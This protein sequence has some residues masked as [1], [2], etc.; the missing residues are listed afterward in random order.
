M[1]CVTLE[2]EKRLG[3]L[4]EIVAHRTV[5]SMAIRAVFHDIAVL[6]HERPLLFHVAPC[7]GFLLGQAKEH[8]LLATA[9]RIMTVGTCHLFLNDRVVGEKSV[10]YLYLRV[11]AIAELRHFV[12]AHFLLRPLVEL[13]AVE[14]ANVIERMGTGVPVS[15]DRCRGG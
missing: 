4:Q 11:A 2:A 8:L 10:L 6:E 5:R 3:G 7:A 13:V 14:A 12:A 1:T 15:K 9:V